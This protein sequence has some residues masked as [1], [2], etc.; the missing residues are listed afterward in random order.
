MRWE[1]QRRRG[2][3][4]AAQWLDFY[5][6][7]VYLFIYVYTKEANRGG[8]KGK[9]YLNNV[10]QIHLQMTW[11][12]RRKRTLFVQQMAL[13]RINVEASLGEAVAELPGVALVGLQ[14][15]PRAQEAAQVLRGAALCASDRPSIPFPSISFLNPP[16]LKFS[17]DFPI[18]NSTIMKKICKR[19]NTTFK[20]PSRNF[21]IRT[22]RWPGDMEL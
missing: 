14:A 4:S 13:R 21:K 5:K 2:L 16:P 3:K 15:R 7:R 10:H 19:L 22:P 6:I 8:I 17:W 1:R 11:K 18:T 12:I 9:T 20:K